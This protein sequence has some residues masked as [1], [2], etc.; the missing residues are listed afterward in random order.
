MELWLKGLL[1]IIIVVC[2]QQGSFGNQNL[3]SCKVESLNRKFPGDFVPDYLRFMLFYWN[4]QSTPPDSLS[5]ITKNQLCLD[6]TGSKLKVAL[7]NPQNEAQSW[8]Q[9]QASLI[10]IQSGTSLQVNGNKCDQKNV[11]IFLQKLIS[12]NTKIR[13]TLKLYQNCI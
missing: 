12:N 13:T 8:Y 4:Q 5:H 10:N 9:Y 7:C 11:L 3:K 2:F 1:R 6:G